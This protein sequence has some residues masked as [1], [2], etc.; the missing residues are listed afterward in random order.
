MHIICCFWRVCRGGWFQFQ[1]YRNYVNKN[2]NKNKVDSFR[3][4]LLEAA[5]F[6][7]PIC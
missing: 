2:K 3:H 5:I 4:L 6:S 7:V 1:A